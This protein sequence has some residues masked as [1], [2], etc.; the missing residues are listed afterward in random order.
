ML[1]DIQLTYAQSLI[2][3]YR[4]AGYRDYVLVE[5]SRYVG[6]NGTYQPYSMFLYLTKGTFTAQSATSFQADEEVIRVSIDTT[7]YNA[8]N[9]NDAMITYDTLDTAFVTVQ[10]Y[11]TTYT[12]AEYAEGVI[13]RQPDL[14]EREGVITNEISTL[15]LLLF[16][17][18]LTAVF[19]RVLR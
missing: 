3:T 1:S 6:N 19:V 17:A 13:Y 14:L 5:A 9:N 8:T 7:N 15:S 16:V 10:D 11:F 12:N 18:V 4:E 2:N